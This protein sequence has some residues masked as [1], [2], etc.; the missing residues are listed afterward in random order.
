[1][2]KIRGLGKKVGRG[3]E[4]ECRL[5]CGWPVEF[6]LSFGV[7]GELWGGVQHLI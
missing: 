4:R 3:E 6:R 2:R 1:M 7:L 5:E